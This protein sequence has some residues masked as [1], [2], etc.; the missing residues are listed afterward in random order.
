MKLL[1][2]GPQGA[3]NAQACWTR[4][5]YPRPSA[6]VEDIA[7]AA[8]TPRGPAGLSRLAQPAPCRGQPAPRPLRRA[9]RQF[10]C[11]GLNYADH[12]AESRPAVPPEPVV[13]Q[14]MDQR[15]L[16]PRRRYPRSR[17]APKTDWEVE[18]GVVIGKPGRYIS[19]ADALSHRGGCASSTTSPSANGRPSAAAPGQGQGLRHVRPGFGPAGFV[20]PDEGG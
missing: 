15:G 13:A 5:G 12:A 20:T 1:R 7:G 3:K 4:R 14:Q 11:I 16:R 8:L 9:D 10:I 19:E 17:A 6:R 2:F 18:L